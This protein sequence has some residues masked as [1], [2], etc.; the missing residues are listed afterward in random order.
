MS[1]QTLHEGACR[2]PGRTAVVYH[3]TPISYALLVNAIDATIQVLERYQLPEAQPVGVVIQHLLDSWV[4]VLALQAL[5]VPTVC[6]RSTAVIDALGFA[7]DIALVTTEPDVARGVVGQFSE[8]SG[9]VICIPAPSLRED[10][11]DVVP[12]SRGDAKFAH[13][14]VYTSGTTGSYKRILWGGA[15]QRQRNAEILSYRRY[16]GADTVYHGTDFGMWTGAGYRIPLRI[17]QLG[18]CVMLDQRPQWCEHFLQPSVTHSTL[19]PDKAHQLLDFLRSRNASTPLDSLEL[20]VTGG[21]M[22][23]AL[24]EELQQRV[25]RNLVYAYGSTEINPLVME[26]TVSDLADLQWLMPLPVRAVEIVDEAGTPC[27]VDVA[28]HLRIRTSELDCTHYLDAPDS[29][30]KVFRQ[31]CFYPGDMAVRRGDGRIRIL[32]RSAD[33]INVRGQKQPVAPLEQELQQRLGVAAVC[34]FSGIDET[35]KEIVAIALEAEQWPEKALL[36]SIGNSL[37]QFEQ[38]Q[39]ALFPRFPRTQ[40]GMSKIDRIALRKRVFPSERGTAAQ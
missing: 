1:Y 8:R 10:I 23:R 31:A 27:P 33:V 13:H 19:T 2:H 17:W 22:S 32:G 20:M 16:C 37:K 7:A 5:G 34:A 40:T 18:G 36:N 4:V 28:G 11:V 24:A 14:I 9:A 25:T 15:L 29:T 35:G 12:A 3:D 26:I 6:A 21:F 39:F 38:V 30:A